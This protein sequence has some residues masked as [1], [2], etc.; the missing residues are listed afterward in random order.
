MLRPTKSGQEIQQQQQQYEGE[1]M[2]MQQQRTQNEEDDMEMQQNTDN[3]GL[4]E[5]FCTMKIRSNIDNPARADFYHQKV[6]RIAKVNSQKLPIL[7]LVQMSA[8][9][10]VLQRNAILTP[11]WN[12][13]FHSVMYV[14][15]GRGRVQVVNHSGQTVFDGELSQGQI[16]LIPQNF[17][18]IKRAYNDGFQWVSFNTNHNAMISKITGKNSMIRSTPL[19]VLMYSK[20]FSTEQARRLKFSRMNEMAIFSPWSQTRRSFD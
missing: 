2:Q 12:I 13:N 7:N 14:T 17:A 9:R 11:Y 10:V 1:S 5:M 16:V 3:N 18:V 6:G 8:S 15:G 19:Q 4:D 20:R